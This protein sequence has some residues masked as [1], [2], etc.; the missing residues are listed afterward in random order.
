MAVSCLQH[1]LCDAVLRELFVKGKV[2]VYGKYVNT[3]LDNAAFAA[4]ET[5]GEDVDGD[6]DKPGMKPLIEARYAIKE[7]SWKK[8]S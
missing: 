8:D 5:S 6:D 2:D 1:A 4:A 7:R 3:G